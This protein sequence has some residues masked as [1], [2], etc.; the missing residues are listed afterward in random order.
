MTLATLQSLLGWC[1][2]INLALLSVWFLLYV[3]AKD[4]MYRLHSR[5][6]A[7]SRER[8]EAIHYGAMAGYKLAI[9]IFNLAPF[10]AL[11]LI[12]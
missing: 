3:L 9:W 5:W 4:A 8:Y 2:V 10:I 1:A 7:L 11:H 6:F 12:Q